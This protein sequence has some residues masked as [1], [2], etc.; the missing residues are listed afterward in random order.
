MHG[1]L[2]HAA[3]PGGL[4]MCS[5]AQVAAVDSGLHI[6]ACTADSD[7]RLSLSDVKPGTLL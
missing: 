5:D 7:M 6:V 2:Q 1:G 3:Y 4:E